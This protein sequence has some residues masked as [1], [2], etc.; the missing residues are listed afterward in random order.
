MK[1]IIAFALALTLAL[2][3]ALA[4]VVVNLPGTAT[5]ATINIRGVDGVIQDCTSR[6]GAA[7][8]IVIDCVPVVV[9]GTVSGPLN[10][11]TGTTPNATN[12]ACVAIT[13]TSGCVVNGVTV[14]PKIIQMDWANPQRMYTTN[15]GGFGA[16]DVIVV[17]FTTG[18]V[19]SD[20]SLPRLAS[21]EYNSSPSSRDA[22]LS[23]L[24]C[25]FA[26]QATPGATII[27]NSITAVFA[28]G[29]GSGFGYYPVLQTNT[30]YYLNMKN[31]AGAS[32]RS[33]GQCDMFI[34]LIKA[35]GL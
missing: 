2:P 17:R 25:D 28:I 27:G 11:A 19:S 20:A 26:P 22:T 23:S 6:T 34:D 3:A 9:T 5:P 33:N 10:C 15:A 16:D 4:S 35:G 30:T 1:R 32:C 24:M 7:G 13:P 29:T 8:V 14:T 21:A 12:T 18:N 31:S